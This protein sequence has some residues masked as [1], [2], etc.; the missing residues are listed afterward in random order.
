MNN[1]VSLAPVL[2]IILSLIKAE[3]SSLLQ[4]QKSLENF[5]ICCK[6][7]QYFLPESAKTDFHLQLS[8]LEEWRVVVYHID[9]NRQQVSQAYIQSRSG[10]VS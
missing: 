3:G 1:L 2:S 6:P 7:V 10:R 9:I 5:L 4:N 8:A